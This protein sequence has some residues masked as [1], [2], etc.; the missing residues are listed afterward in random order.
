MKN[1]SIIVL[2]LLVLATGWL[3]SSN[4]QEGLLYLEGLPDGCPF[5]AQASD[6]YLTTFA[7]TH[8]NQ[9]QTVRLQ[10]TAEGFETFLTF[11]LG[12]QYSNITTEQNGKVKNFVPNPPTGTTEHSE[13]RFR[14]TQ[15][16]KYRIEIKAEM[17]GAGIAIEIFPEDPSK[18]RCVHYTESAICIRPICEDCKKFI[19]KPQRS[20]LL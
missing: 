15:R 7:W 13:Y 1:K 8:Q 9:T 6:C 19:N 16:S 12:Q 10:C 17:F 3:E 11:L 14:P 18:N 5:I 4:P 20:R 2:L